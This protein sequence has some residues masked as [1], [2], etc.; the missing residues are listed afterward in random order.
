MHV[1]MSMYSSYVCMRNSYVCMHMYVH[2]Y[3]V[4][5]NVHCNISCL[6][7]ILYDDHSSCMY[8]YSISRSNITFV[9]YIAYVCINY[10]TIK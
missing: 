7:Y 8:M 10:N 9:F 4:M 3:V 1:S 5:Q 6:V 2:P